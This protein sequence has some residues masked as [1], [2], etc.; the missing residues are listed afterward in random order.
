MDTPLSQRD[1]R[2]GSLKL[3]NSDLTIASDGCLLTSL[4]FLANVT[5]DIANEKLKSVSGFQGALVIW[6]KVQEALP[7]LTLLK[8][9]Y[10]SS[11][12]EGYCVVEVDF[13]GTPATDDRHWVVSVPNRNEYM[14]P[15]VGAWV[16]K[17]K[18]PIVKGFAHFE[19]Q[20]GGEDPVKIA[21]L[22]QK[23][24]I[25][26]NEVVDKQKAIT[27]YEGQLTEYRERVAEM[28]Q[29]MKNVNELEARLQTMQD[30]LVSM[31]EK[32][33]L[34]KKVASNLR[35]DISEKEETIGKL[36]QS[37]ETLRIEN[38]RLQEVLKISESKKIKTWSEWL[39]FIAKKVKEVFPE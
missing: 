37:V 2:W 7:S 9:G 15:W 28:E 31:D 39:N 34:E 16:P 5:P 36:T 24:S 10:T 18:F 1:K 35:R 13:D 21:E 19:I 26:T 29:K 32:V 3:G 27:A 17:T 14:D 22:E 12:P 33:G 6:A 38:G 30:T 11:V 8:R 25:L 20:E 23:I 4:S